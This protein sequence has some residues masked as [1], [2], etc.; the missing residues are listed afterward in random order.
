MGHFCLPTQSS[1]CTAIS[2]LDSPS[3][4]GHLDLPVVRTWLLVCPTNNLGREA[5]SGRLWG[6]QPGQSISRRA[7]SR[8]YSIILPLRRSPSFFFP[9]FLFSL[10]SF[11]ND[12]QARG[13]S[14]YPS[15]TE[16]TGFLFQICHVATA[17]SPLFSSV[18]ILSQLPISD[19]SD[20]RTKS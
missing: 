18:P 17:R 19:F 6:L 14:T 5:G 13:T 11:L 15:H 8:G 20:F 16:P 1:K 9:F 10:L 7:T 3:Q 2:R 12:R 4:T